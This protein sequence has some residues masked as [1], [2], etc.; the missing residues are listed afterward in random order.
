[1]S[2]MLLCYIMFTFTVI[3]PLDLDFI[4]FKFIVSKVVDF[5]DNFYLDTWKI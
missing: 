5:N 2:W 4:V 3:F 1:M